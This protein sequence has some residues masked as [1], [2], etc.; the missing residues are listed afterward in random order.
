MLLTNNYL[1]L[2][3]YFC[4]HFFQY[5]CTHCV[6]YFCTHSVQYLC[7]HSFQYFCTL[8]VQYFCTHSVQYFC[9]HSVQ[10]FSC[11]C[12]CL[13]ANRMSLEQGKL[14]FL[15]FKICVRMI[16]LNR[17]AWLLCRKID[18]IQRKS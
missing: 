10:Y 4:T 8:S 9:T 18:I 6:Q 13:A 17:Y 2:G 1:S 16:Q 14:I 12:V 5:L 7:T 15:N 11:I 3:G